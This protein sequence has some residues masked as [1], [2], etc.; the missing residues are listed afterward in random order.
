[1]LAVNPRGSSGRG[2]AF[3]QAQM[4]RWGTVDVADVSAGISHVLAMGVA[5]PDA[6]GVGGWSYGGILSN[7]MIASDARVK[8]AVA[9]AGMAN[10]IGGY[11]VDQYAR[12]YELEL[13]LPWEETD[14]WLALS[15]PFLR[16]ERIEAATLY[17]CA[18]EDWN[19]PCSGSLQMYQALRAERV[20]TQLVV[21]PG[22]THSL[23]VPSYLR[24]RIERSLDWYDRYLKQDN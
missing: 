4:A 22:E 6:I 20:P 1:V 12:E 24:D 10:F 7:Y 2:A 14:R 13:G 9:G 21:Y 19:V 17:L 5:D 15:Y 11:G 3:A 8:A 16:A 23:S 18:E